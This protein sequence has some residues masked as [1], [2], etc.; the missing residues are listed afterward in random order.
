MACSQ[1]QRYIVFYVWLNKKKLRKRVTI[2]VGKKTAFELQVKGAKS[3]N[4]PVPQVV[5]STA[6][7][8][9]RAPVRANEA[10]WSTARRT[11]QNNIGW[12]CGAEM[13]YKQHG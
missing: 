4:I 6:R 7:A 9:R 10:L 13:Q 5:H 8:L 12:N 11:E 2:V 3:V 1:W